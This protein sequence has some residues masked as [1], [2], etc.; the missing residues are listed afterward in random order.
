MFIFNCLYFFVCLFFFHIFW[1]LFIFQPLF[2]E[3]QYC[4]GKQQRKESR[5]W[6]PHGQNGSVCVTLDLIILI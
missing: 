3:K 2:F 5:Q 6:G 1:Y 4:G